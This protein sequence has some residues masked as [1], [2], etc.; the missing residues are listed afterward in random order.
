MTSKTRP[1]PLNST[2]G[3]FLYYGPIRACSS[4]WY[5]ICHIICTIS[6][7]YWVESS[8]MSFFVFP[9]PRQCPDI[10]WWSLTYVLSC[11]PFWSLSNT[12]AHQ[13][14]S[15]PTTGAGTSHTLFFIV[16]DLWACPFKL[17][18]PQGQI[19]CFISLS[20]TLGLALGC[21]SR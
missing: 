7:F 20:Q 18:A 12:H 9:P 2:E 13:A 6:I 5:R 21:Y 1:Q 4:G 14:D 17:V 10:G 15:S 16:H 11:D 3:T 19:L 8:V